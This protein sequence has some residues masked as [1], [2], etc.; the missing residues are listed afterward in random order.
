MVG[1]PTDR[2]DGVTDVPPMHVPASIRAVWG[3]AERPH[4]GPRRGLSLERIVDAAIAVAGAEGLDAVS[5]SRVASELGSSAMSLYRYV[6]SKDELLALMLDV[7]MGLPPDPPAD[8]QAWREGLATW[9]MAAVRRYLEAPWTVRVPVPAPPIAPNQIRWL[10]AGLSCLRGTR[11]AEREK[12]STILLLSGL[13]RYQGSLAA[14][15]A[16]AMQATGG[17]DPTIGYGAALRQLADPADFPAVYAAVASGSLDDDEDDFTGD[18]LRFGLDR[19]LDGLEILVR[20]RTP[21]PP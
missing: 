11:L 4:P 6:G 13:A 9:S 2:P 20:R 14:D 3:K 7:G 16:V 10:E 12:L 5:M 17:M 21:S 18:E 15:V 19:I 1:D 8:P